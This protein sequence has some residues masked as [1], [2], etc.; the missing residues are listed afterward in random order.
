MP[1]HLKF[2]AALSKTD[3]PAWSKFFN[4]THAAE[5]T[6]IT[7]RKLKRH[8]SQSDKNK[9]NVNREYQAS[10]QTYTLHYSLLKIGQGAAFTLWVPIHKE[11]RKQN[12]STQEEKIL[13]SG[14][15][16]IVYQ[17]GPLIFVACADDFQ[18]K[19]IN[20]QLVIK[21]YKCNAISQMQFE[22]QYHL[23][24]QLYD[25]ISLS[26]TPRQY[27]IMPY[28]GQ[29][30]FAFLMKQRSELSL[31]K[32]HA[33]AYAV[34]NAY[35]LFYSS[36]Q[37][38]HR[39][40]KL[41]NFVVDDA[42]RVRI[43]D[44]GYANSESNFKKTPGLGEAFMGTVFYMAPEVADSKQIYNKKSDVYSLG[45]VLALIYDLFERDVLAKDDLK[46]YY[47]FE[48]YSLSELK[49]K[50]AQNERAHAL[51][52]TNSG[53]ALQ[54]TRNRLSNLLEA[55]PNKRCTLNEALVFFKAQANYEALHQAPDYKHHMLTV[56]RQLI[57]GGFSDNQLNKRWLEARTKRRQGKG[58][59]YQ[60]VLS[61]LAF[62]YFKLS[63]SEN[64][65]TYDKVWH[66]KKIKKLC[67]K[68]NEDAF[69]AVVAEP[70][71]YARQFI[72]LFKT[73]E[74]D[75]DALVQKSAQERITLFQNKETKLELTQGI[76]DIAS[77]SESIQKNTLVPLD[78]FMQ[79]PISDNMSF[80][81]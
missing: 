22:Q 54:D 61:G 56:Y 60:K 5:D 50:V 59:A 3:A 31:V 12:N 16:G 71:H 48:G 36:T 76:Q 72:S 27:L 69:L 20:V 4:L 6:D 33:L 9:A 2:T 44:F 46:E 17:G 1:K 73:D 41:E 77:L 40:I 53:D 57:F 14:G 26:Y 21:K 51:K 68:L 25:F 74:T 65:P 45:V 7:K 79:T 32:Q 28:F 10:G 64:I 70:R 19:L 62:K 66:D 30:L 38:F 58:E 37:H 52:A 43:I 80:F 34:L 8:I 18:V 49:K 11:K 55:N 47:R 81:A 29:S 42:G 78:N 15:E 23:S 35:Q 67:A 63:A 75:R 39:D 13:G 24:K